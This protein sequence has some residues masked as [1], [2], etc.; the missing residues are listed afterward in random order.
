MAMGKKSSSR[1]QGGMWVAT[2]KLPRS[3]GYPFYERLNQ[4]LEKGDLSFSALACLRFPYNG[5]PI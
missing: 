5:S 1:R 4:V 2:Q 3:P